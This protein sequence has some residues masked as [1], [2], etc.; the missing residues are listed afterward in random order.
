MLCTHGMEMLFKGYDVLGHRPCKHQPSSIA[1][2]S[3]EEPTVSYVAMVSPLEGME[4][5]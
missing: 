5:Q 1:I 4:R 3:L 2:C